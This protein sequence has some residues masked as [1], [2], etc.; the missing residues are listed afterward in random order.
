MKDW[1]PWPRHDP[2]NLSD[3]GKQ[4]NK[5]AANSSAQTKKHSLII[6]DNGVIMSLS[7]LHL[8]HLL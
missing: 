6:V 1:D 3:I 4:R 2:H 5:N 7:F 8:D